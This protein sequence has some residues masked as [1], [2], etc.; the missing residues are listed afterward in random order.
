[1]NFSG[2]LLGLELTYH[3]ISVSYCKTRKQRQHMHRTKIIKSSLV[4]TKNI[5]LKRYFAKEI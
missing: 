3:T 4:E 2:I 5:L 1:M